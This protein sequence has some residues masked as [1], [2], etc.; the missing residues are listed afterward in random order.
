MINIICLKWGNKYGPEYVNRLYAMV[1]RHTTKDFRFWCLTEAAQSI[2]PEVS[3]VPLKFANDL[4]SWWNKIWLFSPDIPIPTGE[5]IFYIDL[6]TVIVSNIDDLLTDQVPDIVMLRD[7]Y[8]GIART[9]GQVGS[10]LMSWRHGAY[11]F[12]WDEFIKDPQTAI[13]SV[14]PHGD[15]AW[16]EHCIDAWYC[17]QDLFPGRVVSFKI[18]CADGMPTSTSIICYHGRPSIPDSITMPMDHSTAMRRWTTKA[19]PWVADHW[20]ED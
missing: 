6:D 11:E 20:K 19:A 10:G 1:R 14:H 2:R 4:D 13:Q 9:A 3:V 7:F 18:D 16:V 15:Q 12:I 17:W 8:Q 5:Q